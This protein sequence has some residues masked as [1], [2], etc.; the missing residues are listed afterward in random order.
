[1]VDAQAHAHAHAAGNSLNKH[2]HKKALFLFLLIV[3]A[4]WVEHITQAVQIWVLDW[5]VPA[6]KGALGL[7]WP[8]LV[9][10]EVMHYGFALIML[11]GIFLL[12]KGFVGRSKKWWAITLGLQFW[13]HLEHLLLIIQA[14]T[15]AYLLDK[16]VPTSVIQLIIPRVELHLFYNTLVFIPMVIAMVMHMRPTPEERS[17]M[18]CTCALPDRAAA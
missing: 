18:Q 17:E 6:A 9:T 5:P 11:V 13:H 4:H 8:W 15:G 1:M 12:R 2:Q 3:I 7:W 16:P 10:S 14:S